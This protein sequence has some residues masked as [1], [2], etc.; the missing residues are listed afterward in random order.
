ML[1]FDHA[2]STPV[3]PDV[4]RTIAE[5]MQVH[6]GNPSSIHRSGEASSKLLERSREVCAAALGGV[7]PE[8]II[9]TSGAT[10]S[11]N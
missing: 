2:A 11:N 4:I 6:N 7:K 10:E 5:V 9:I 3:N 1:N 8:E